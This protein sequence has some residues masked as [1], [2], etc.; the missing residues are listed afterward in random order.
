[1]LNKHSGAE[2]KAARQAAILE[3][4]AS[5]EVAT[6]N[7]LVRALKRRGIAATQVSISR[8]VAELGLIKSGGAYRPAP[9]EGG[10]ADP[11]LPLRTFVRRVVAAGPHLAVVRC[12]AGTA[13]RVGLV[14]D[15]LAIPGL[16]GT[17]AGDDAVFVAT[18]T[19]AAQKKLV[20]FLQAR[21]PK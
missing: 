17:L 6:Q 8:D 21:M 16:A 9:A 20:E 18:E 13:P 12:D 2:G 14:L 19:A 7:D 5:A 10:A 11:E 4:V 1:M 3:V 15:G